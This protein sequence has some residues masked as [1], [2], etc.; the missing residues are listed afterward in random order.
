MLWGLVALKVLFLSEKGGVCLGC[1]ASLARLLLCHCRGWSGEP[2]SPRS[3]RGWSRASSR[4]S[5]LVL[6]PEDDKR[7][8]AQS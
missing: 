2:S 3:A 6:A 7:S 4:R 1:D 5:A 8:C